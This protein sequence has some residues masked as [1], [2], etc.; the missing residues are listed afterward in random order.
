MFCLLRPN[1][2]SRVRDSQ[3]KS[4]D[5]IPHFVHCGRTL[6]MREGLKARKTR[7]QFLIFPV[8]AEPSL[9]G[10]GFTAEE[11][12]HNASILLLHPYLSA[13]KRQEKA[14]QSGHNASILFFVSVPLCR[15]E[16]GK[17]KIVRLQSFNS[18]HCVRTY[19]HHRRICS[20]K[21]RIQ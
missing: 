1:Y 15:K 4:T 20:K 6:T 11:S 14:S 2:S 7:L 18:A 17:C 8:V 19:R 13:G 21:V 5:T 3:D 12:G 9:R 10:E 16:A